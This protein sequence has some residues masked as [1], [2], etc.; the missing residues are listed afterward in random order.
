MQMR[1][2]AAPC[3]ES[4][5][6]PLEGATMT[7]CA[8]SVST[9]PTNLQA[10]STCTAPSQL[11]GKTVCCFTEEE[12]YIAFMVLLFIPYKEGGGE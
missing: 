11:H 4:A 9:R 12:K 7:R 8:M 10:L 6:H 2:A 1:Y 3:Q 5:V